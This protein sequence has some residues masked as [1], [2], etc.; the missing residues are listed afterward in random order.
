VDKLM[1][2]A[3][4][5]C[6]Q[7]YDRYHAWVNGDYILRHQYLGPIETRIQRSLRS[8]LLVNSGPISLICKNITQ[9]TKT[10][11]TFR[12]EGMRI[13]KYKPGQYGV[14]RLIVEGTSIQRSWTISNHATRTNFLEITTKKIGKATKYM[15][16][17][18]QVG[19]KIEL[20]GIEGNFICPPIIRNKIL[21]LTAG[22][23]ITPIIAMLRALKAQK[24][25]C[26]IILLHAEK[27]PNDVCFLDEILE[28]TNKLHLS[29]HFAFSQSCEKEPTGSKCW[30][31]RVDEKILKNVV[32]DAEQREVY[33]CGPEGF[34]RNCKKW[35]M[36]MGTEERMIHSEDFT[37]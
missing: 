32:Q 19:D 27:T 5:D 11:K 18:M 2:G 24:E 36:K 35:L 30:N 1:L 7:L 9:V 17:K 31:G 22:I 6:T 25:E 10:V 3:G 20:V 34:M 16:E 13:L 14:F 37:I 12:F 33:M 8:K 15:H 26:D 28:M 23:G 4:T 21:F 29:I